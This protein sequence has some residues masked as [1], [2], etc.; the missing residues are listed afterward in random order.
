MPRILTL[1][2]DRLAVCRLEPE[3]PVPGWALS[4][5]FSSVTRTPGELSV[6]CAEADLPAGRSPLPAERSPRPA[7]RS[8]LPAE[9]SPLPA[10]AAA[11]DLRVERGF[12]A[13]RVE[14]PLD[15]ALAGV[16]AGL[17]APLARAG[18]PVFAL[19]TFDTD[20][21]L[22]RGAQ[23]EEA[24]RALTEVAEVRRSP[25]RARSAGSRRPGPRLPAG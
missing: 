25:G 9:R 2:P 19:S 14:G 15:F 22:V 6:V 24:A 11:A 1:L 4:G 16:L 5:A 23:A 3:A 20:Y 21:L 10:A 18:I 12:R 7:E 17:L 8:P 13:F